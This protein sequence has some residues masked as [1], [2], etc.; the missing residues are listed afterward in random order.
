MNFSY[1]SLDPVRIITQ[2]AAKLDANRTFEGIPTVEQAP[3]GRLFAAWYAG[4]HG[5][6]FDN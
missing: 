2:D 6:G 1:I 5:E 3:S 4:G